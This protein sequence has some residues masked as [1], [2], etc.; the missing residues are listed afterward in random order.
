MESFRCAGILLL[1]CQR[2]NFGHRQ[3]LKFC[4]FQLLLCA[5]K[6]P[7]SPKVFNRFSKSL[8]VLEDVEGGHLCG[9]FMVRRYFTFAMAR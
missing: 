1:Q 4:H 7:I 2:E 6:N 3:H 9:K 5:S 8:P